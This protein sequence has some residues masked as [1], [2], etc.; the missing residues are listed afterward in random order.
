M[1]CSALKLTIPAV[2]LSASLAISGPLGDTLGGVSDTVSDT[3]GGVTDTAGDVVGGVSDTVGGVSAGV[4][5]D[6]DV[7]VGNIA[8]V[9]ACVGVGVNSGPG[10]CGGGQMNAVSA[11]SKIKNEPN[12]TPKALNGFFVTG[13][14]GSPL[15]SVR[16]SKFEA[17]KVLWIVVQL[18]DQRKVRVLN[19]ISDVS[20]G[21]VWLKIPGSVVKKHASNKMKR[22]IVGC[23]DREVKKDVQW[24]TCNRV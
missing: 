13:S 19:G 2:F 1:T 14:D 22:L 21:A 18:P 11:L 20:D 7:G 23:T 5:V 4:G 10:G 17:G 16:A 24:N 6:V 15:G 12:I 3:V 8:N 9:D